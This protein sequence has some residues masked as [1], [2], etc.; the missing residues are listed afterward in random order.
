MAELNDSDLVQSLPEDLE[1][2][3]AAFND[4]LSKLIDKHAPVKTKSMVNERPM[5][6]WF[7]DQIKPANIHRRKLERI[8]KR[9]G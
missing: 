7:N 1:S 3:T 6:L 8:K 2:L 4:T 9:S 5:Q